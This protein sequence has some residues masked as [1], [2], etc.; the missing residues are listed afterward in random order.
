MLGYFGKR[1]L[2]LIPTLFAVLTLA[3]V[4][5]RIV[6]GDPALII[7]G[8]QATPEAIA[9]FHEATGLDQP[10]WRQ[11]LAFLSQLAHGDLGVSM[12]S[13]RPVLTSIIEVLPYTLELSFAG[14]LVGVVLGVPLG[15]IAARSNGGV[16]DWAIRIVT[17]GGL[18]FP[19]FVSAVLMLLVFAVWLGWFPV[20]STAKPI[21]DP[22]GRLN[23]LALP[24]INL[25][26]VMMAY[27]ARVTRGGM[28][29]IMRSDYIRTARA[30]GVPARRIVWKHALRN[31]LLAVVTF[32]GLYFSVLIGNS[33]LTEIVFNR[34]G[35][36]KLVIGAL[37]RRDYTL[38]Q[39]LVVA[40]AILVVLVNALTD[41]CYGLV[42]PRVKTS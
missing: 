29:N 42:D 16:A 10:I 31:V 35:L 14:V 34:P 33:V 27:V 5:V 19:A 25:G 24:A 28:M 15:V 12:I 18:S 21:T 39:G 36:G 30:K 1:L 13:N 37:E 17:L 38:L 20:I 2:T 9:R 23:S 7:L 41:L 40:Y 8:D 26:L 22:I 3:F 6:P 32:T 11:F 4:L